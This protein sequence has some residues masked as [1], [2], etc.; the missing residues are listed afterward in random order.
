MRFQTLYVSV[1]KDSLNS[2]R[3]ICGEY[4]WNTEKLERDGATKEK[5]KTNGETESAKTSGNRR[6]LSL[7]LKFHVSLGAKGPMEMRTFRSPAG[8]GF[9]D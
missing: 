5:E 9:D 2:R 6:L 7:L 4:L 3:L 8:L 1:T